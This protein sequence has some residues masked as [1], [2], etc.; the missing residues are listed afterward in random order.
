MIINNL[1][2]NDKNPPYMIAEMSGNHAGDIKKAKDI[3]RA[4]KDAGADAIKIQTYTPDTMTINTDKESFIVHDGLWSERNLY[5]LYQE[6]HTPWEWHDELFNEAVKCGIT[7]FS[8]PFDTTAVD[9]LEKLN[10]PAYKIASAELI[11]LNLITRV[12]ETKK[13]I[14]LSTGMANLGEIEESVNL[15]N[16]YS[17]EYALLHCISGYPTE[18]EELNLTTL[19][20]LKSTFNTIVG[21]SDHTKGTIAPLVAVSLGANII[22]KHVTLS[23]D[24]TTVDS[25]FSISMKEFE[26]LKMD[27]ELAWKAVGKVNYSCAPS[28]VPITKFRRSLYVVSDIQKGDE[29]TIDNVKSI[30]PAGGLKPK[31]LN[32][33]IGKKSR[34]F[35]QK[36][37]PLNWEYIE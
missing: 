22:E 3:I 28:E 35:L 24:D 15:L 7:L 11:D 34:K 14:I 19:C 26:I 21:F 17:V 30:R 1:K 2:I 20:N 31:Y 37:T 23:K 33:I 29:F 8:T 32:E 10:V 18:V 36:G 4:A 16:K 13:P 9:F 6:A 27:C 25:E 12:C 5:E